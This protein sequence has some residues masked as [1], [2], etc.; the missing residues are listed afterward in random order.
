MGKSFSVGRK[1]R[2]ASQR[3]MG[4]ADVAVVPARWTA[5]MLGESV[6]EFAVDELQVLAV[7]GNGTA[8]R[9]SRP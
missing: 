8:G 6:A 3:F 1:A 7:D 2:G 5:A 4:S 9:S